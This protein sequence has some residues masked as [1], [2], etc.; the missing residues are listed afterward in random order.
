MGDLWGFLWIP[1]SWR[2]CE[3]FLWALGH[4][5]GVGVPVNPWVMGDVCGVPVGPWVMGDV[6][7]SVGPWGMCGV[8]RVARL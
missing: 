2:M 6:G 7:G 1:G 3:G 8:L 4:G 5:G